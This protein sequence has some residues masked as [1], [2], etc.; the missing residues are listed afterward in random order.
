M[1]AYYERCQQIDCLP[2]MSSHFRE[3]QDLLTGERDV[4]SLL[5]QRRKI[6]KSEAKKQDKEETKRGNQGNQKQMSTGESKLIPEKKKCVECKQETDKDNRI[7]CSGCPNC[8]C[9]AC[10]ACTQ[11]SFENCQHCSPHLLFCASCKK[12][13]YYKRHSGHRTICNKH[14]NFTCKRC[15]VCEKSV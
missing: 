15:V 5:D 6:K 9:R 11:S 7:S 8:I 12:V 10:H 13:C 3:T 4:A 2:R 14:W 1:F